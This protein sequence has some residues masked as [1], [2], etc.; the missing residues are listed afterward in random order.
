MD[1]QTIQKHRNNLVTCG[2]GI[3]LFGFW[4]VIQI[5]T[6][7]LY[8]S[9]SMAQA[10]ESVDEEYLT[11]V[12]IITFIFIMFFLAIALWI[13]ALIAI[14]AMREGKQKEGKRRYFVLCL[15]LCILSVMSAVYSVVSIEMNRL[16][17]TYILGILGNLTTFFLTLSLMISTVRVRRYDREHLPDNNH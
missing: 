9:T 15:M 13:R 10:F 2:T 14:R 8:N 11:A 5:F 12:R 6:G 16:I 1:K 3:L 4:D 17:F 7:F